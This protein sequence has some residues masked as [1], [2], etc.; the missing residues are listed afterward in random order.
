[1][2]EIAM[3]M[4]DVLR[5]LVDLL[6][7][8]SEFNRLV[9]RVDDL[10]SAMTQY[11]DMYSLAVEVSAIAEL[12]RHGADRRIGA[13]QEETPAVARRRLQRDQEFVDAFIEACDFLLRVTPGALTDGARDGAA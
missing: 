2:R 12:R 3:E 9:A 13:P 7:R 10:R 8:P 5:R 11:D 6:E 1:M 4:R